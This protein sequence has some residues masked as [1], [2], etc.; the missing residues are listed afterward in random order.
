VVLGAGGVGKTTLAAGYALALARSGRHVGLLGIDPSH[1]LQGALGLA[2]RDGPVTF[3]AGLQAALLLPQETLRRWA[4]EGTDD[5]D[6]RQRLLHNVFFIALSSRLASANEVIAAA[7]V[8][9][10]VEQDPL[11]TDLVVDTAPGRAG[12]E[13]LRR[14]ESVMAFLEGPLVRWL[15]RLSSVEHAGRIVWVLR[16]RALHVIS[17]MNKIAGTRAVLE[18]AELLALVQEPFERLLE[19][20]EAARSWLRSD[21]A[22]LLLVTTV[23]D[24]AAAVARVLADELRSTRLRPRA[25]IV[26][27]VVPDAFAR[28]LPPPE[29]A[30]TPEAAALL[31]YAHAYAKV[32]ARVLSASAALA[33]VLVALPAVPDLGSDQRLEAL[34]AIGETLRTSLADA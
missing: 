4:S 13:F 19:R 14:P 12:L 32:Q 18:L 25:V 34:A 11:L 1:R 6:V 7:R 29:E 16:G 23:R 24:D 28:D 31:R 10:W 2:L 8:A 17:G 9:E 20:V 26:N 30:P 5:P 3:D 15:R 33:P 27:R 21:A 22:R